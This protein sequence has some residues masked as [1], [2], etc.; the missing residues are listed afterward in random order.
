[1]PE[2]TVWLKPNGAPIATT[3]SPT[4]TESESPSFISGNFL[5]L[6]IFINAKSVPL[7]EPSTSASY[8]SP[9]LENTLISS[10]LSIT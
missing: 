10:A 8:S 5:S 1:M 4:L 6:V 2:V 9:S 7:S 3:E